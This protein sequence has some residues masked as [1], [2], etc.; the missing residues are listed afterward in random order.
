MPEQ[1]PDLDRPPPVGRSD[2]ETAEFFRKAWRFD[3]FQAVKVLEGM[4]RIERAESGEDTAPAGSSNNPDEEALRFT[5]TVSLAHQA[6]DIRRVIAWPRDHE[7]PKMQVNFLGLT[8]ARGP[9]PNWYAELIRDRTILGDHGLRAFLDLF[10]H[11]LVSLFYRVR[12]R[13]RPTLHTERPETH[14]FAGYLLSFAGLGAPAARECLAEARE[15]AG[16]GISPR[17]LIFYAGFFWQRERSMVGLERL[18]TRYFG[19]EFTGRELTG[20]WLELAPEERSSLTTRVG[21]NRLGV[22]TICGARVANPQSGFELCLD[23]LDWKD[24]VDFLPSGARLPALR[25]L[26]NLYVRSAFDF[27]LRLRV[28]SQAVME[29]RPALSTADGPRLGWTSWALTR[30]LATAVAEIRVPASRQPTL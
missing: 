1:Q 20:G 3:F 23:D 7:Q 27:H 9:M 26:V 2:A 24:F 13:H 15:E 18:L 11:R 4:V 21:H 10:N 29:S 30:P 17:E 12:Q 22:T 5:S 16:A 14:P 6:S 28:K 19:I 8:G 25:Q